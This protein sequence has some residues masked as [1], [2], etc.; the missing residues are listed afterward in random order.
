VKLHVLNAV[1]L[2]TYTLKKSFQTKL[3]SMLITAITQHF[4]VQNVV[5]HDIYHYQLLYLT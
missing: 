2:P 1:S 5:Q 3:V 4:L